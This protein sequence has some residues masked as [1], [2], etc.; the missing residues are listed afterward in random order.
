MLSKAFEVL[1]KFQKLLC[2]HARSSL[3]LFG[4]SHTSSLGSLQILNL[5]PSLQQ[6]LSAILS[7]SAWA[8]I[9][10]NMLLATTCCCKYSSCNSF[11]SAGPT[12]RHPYRHSYYKNTHPTR[13]AFLPSVGSSSHVVRECQWEEAYIRDLFFLVI[14]MPPLTTIITSLTSPQIRFSLCSLL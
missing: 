11:A 13:C 6:E 3:S 10:K 1:Y 4:P 5:P 2:E 12:T 14:S 9:L 7:C 8:T